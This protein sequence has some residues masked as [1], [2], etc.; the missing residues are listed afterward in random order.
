[1]MASLF[2]PSV[3]ARHTTQTLG[4]VDRTS[5]VSMETTIK[6]RDVGRHTSQGL[7]T[8][9][10]AEVLRRPQI[11]RPGNLGQGE[12]AGSRSHDGRCS[13]GR[14]LQLNRIHGFP[15]LPGKAENMRHPRVGSQTGGRGRSP[16]PR[17]LGLVVE[18]KF[19]TWPGANNIQGEAFIYFEE[20]PLGEVSFFIFMCPQPRRVRCY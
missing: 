17:G 14:V 6:K 2:E 12:T 11:L 1:M 15:T 7:Q 9:C 19:Q 4:D 18:G 5:S 8:V 13:M 20:D 16:S 3:R 10:S